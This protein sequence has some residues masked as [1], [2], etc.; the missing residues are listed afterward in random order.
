MIVINNLVQLQK[1]DTAIMEIQE[2][3]GDL[4]KNVKEL[5]S[6]INNVNE[7]ISSAEKRLLE[8]ELEIR[9]I[10]T[11]EQDHKEKISTLEDKLY[12]A[13]TN[14]EYDAFMSEIDHLKSQL[15]NEEIREL[16]LSEEQDKLNETLN[17][18]RSEEKEM[19]QN[20]TTQKE[21]LDKQIKETEEEYS[22]LNNKRQNLIKDINDQDLSIYDRVRDAKEGLAVVPI[23]NHAC[24][25]CH[26][27]IPA[28]LE[29][30]IRSAEKIT[31]CSTCRRILYWENPEVY[32]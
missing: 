17:N 12:L 19:S 18:D 1:I 7:T 5:T 6:T 24:G 30:I 2:L 11:L 32:S 10:Q 22:E 16:E 25:G 21:E 31:Q 27:R 20:L 3:Q 23:T 29:S 26:S 14:R 13:K 4:P 8:I 9:K 28:Q 15:D